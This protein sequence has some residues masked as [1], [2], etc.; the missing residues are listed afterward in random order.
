MSGRLQPNDTTLAIQFD[1]AKVTEQHVRHIASILS[2]AIRALLDAGAKEAMDNKKDILYGWA[3]AS[4]VEPASGVSL[5]PD[6]LEQIWSWNSSV[7]KTSTLT[8]LDLIDRNVQTRPNSPAICAWDGEATYAELDRLASG[9]AS[10]LL[11]FGIGFTSIV[12]LCFEKS[13]WCPVAM[14]AVM[15]TGAAS[16]IMDMNQ[17]KGRLQAIIAQVG[18]SVIVTSAKHENLGRT[19]VADTSEVVVASKATVTTAPAII[20]EDQSHRPK[21]SDLLYMVFTSG[22]T[23]NPKGTM[24][25]HGNISTSILHQQAALGLSTASR[26]YDFA[27]YSFDVAWC[28]FFHALTCG[29]CLCVPSESDRFNRVEGSFTDLRANYAHITPT[30]LR[31]LDFSK[32]KEISVLNLSGEE[33]LSTDGHLV[34]GHVKVVNAYGPAETNVVTVQDLFTSSSDDDVVSIGRGAGVCTWI[35]DSVDG[36]SLVAL[37]D[38]GEL[39]IEGPLVGRGY[40]N[41]IEKTSQSFI[42]DPEWLLQGFNGK[43]GRQGTLYKTGDLVYYRDDGTLVYMGRKDTQVKIRGQRV[44]LGEI[45]CQLRSALARLDLGKTK[46]VVD[47]AKPKASSQSILTAFICINST[48][49]DTS[50]EDGNTFHQVATRIP[51]LLADV[52][53]PYMIPTAFVFVD[54]MPQTVS[55]KTDRR[56][57]KEH[58]SGMTLREIESLHTCPSSKILPRTPQEKLLQSLWAKVLNMRDDEISADDIFFRIGGDSLGAMRLV[59]LARSHDVFFTVGQIF[60]HPMLSSLALLCE[61]QEEPAVEAVAP[62]ELLADSFLKQNMLS[63]AADMCCVSQERIVNVLPCTALQADLMQR[64]TLT[65]DKIGFA[66]SHCMELHR[67]TDLTRFRRAWDTVVSR[68][69]ILRTRMIPLDSYGWLQVVLDTNIEWSY[70]QTIDEHKS[71][72]QESEMGPGTALLRLNIIDSNTGGPKY[73]VIQLHWA[74]YDGWAIRM[75][76]AE[77]ERI[78]RDSTWNGV[79]RDMSSFIKHIEQIDKTQ[80]ISF[81]K[82]QFSGCSKEAIF[83]QG[84]PVSKGTNLCYERYKEVGV[85]IKE[86]LVQQRDFTPAIVVRAALGLVIANTNG[87]DDAVFGATVIGRQAS[88]PEMDRMTGPAF[89]TLPIRIRVDHN[90]SVR[91]LLSVV[92]TQATSMIPYEQVS[93]ASIRQT[94]NEAALACGF[95]TLLV[96]Q[97]SIKKGDPRHRGGAEVDGVCQSMYAHELVAGPHAIIELG[98]R[99]GDYAI[100]VE[101]KLGA[102]ASDP[103][104]L[105]VCIDSEVVSDKE[106]EA[107]ARELAT[108]VRWL[109][110]IENADCKVPSEGFQA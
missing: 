42:R 11:Q 93:L 80:A 1:D 14:L 75:M 104:S 59:S 30:L 10:K 101:C 25:T 89:V 69:S 21:Y 66:S 7:P 4:S 86:A 18:G 37:G 3:A 109:G 26:V 55:G 92:Q 84:R 63:V 20:Q 82:Q 77:A 53:P 65:K 49:T 44:E 91:E 22:S 56:K 36:Q 96:I 87:S 9:L 57:L 64:T 106:A 17:P 43:H 28:N 47:V 48:N 61:P 45:E 98:Q 107:F 68:A 34:P 46:F 12:P 19:L 58:V 105:R 74:A 27:S 54:E 15:K 72:A 110:N 60:Q 71:H 6:H 51:D 13:M 39:W 23:G 78:Y 100:Y 88:V 31:S 97:S 5:K 8:I 95:Q 94:S 99:T 24:L 50:S 40:F 102:L 85:P 29:G 67:D 90:T 16:V 38:V 2:N 103:V 33:V 79:L 73:F 70:Y 41:D 83:P 32:M 81:W 52:L 35:V 62:F 76:F 108:A